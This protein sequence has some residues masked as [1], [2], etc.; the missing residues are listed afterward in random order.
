MGSRFFS[1]GQMPAHDLFLQFG[2]DLVTVDRWWVGGEHYARTLEAWLRLYD[3]R[4]DALTPI[5]AATYGAEAAAEWRVDWRLFL[6]ACAET[7]AY[8]GGR[9]WGVSHYLLAPASEGPP[10]AGAIAGDDARE[11][12][13]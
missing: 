4:A 2:D 3:D 7:F 12:A 5:L 1:G 6:L 9:Q 13:A 11:A 10:R 8:D